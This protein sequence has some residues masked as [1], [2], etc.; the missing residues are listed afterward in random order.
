MESNS[1][2]TLHNSIESCY[3]LMT[4]TFM[5]CHMYLIGSFYILVFLHLGWYCYFIISIMFILTS[6]LAL[7][8]KESIYRYLVYNKYNKESFVIFVALQLDQITPNKKLRWRLNKAYENNKMFE[9]F[10]DPNIHA[11]YYRMVLYN[12]A[13]NILTCKNIVGKMFI[14]RCLT[15]CKITLSIST[16]SIYNGSFI[17]PK[18]LW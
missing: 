4:K 8:L 3:L 9:Q 17:T 12:L 1:K 13:S 11:K 6:L 5:P 16:W 10:I 14:T 18:G 7:D 15:L 2:S